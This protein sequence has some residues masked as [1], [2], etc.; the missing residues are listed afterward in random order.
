MFERTH[1]CG[2]LRDSHVGERV[3]VAG[4]VQKR[5]DH[6]GLIF[7]DL[8][9]RSG[10]VQAVVDPNAAPDAF[11]AAHRVRPEFVL[12]VRG[13]VRPRPEGTVNPNLPTGEVEVEMEGLEVLNASKTPPFEIEDDVD[14]D[15]A[16]RL[17]YRYLD[18]RRRPMLENLILRDRIVQATRAYLGEQGFLEVETP[19]LTKSTPEGARDFL[20]PSRLQPG[21]FYALPQSPQLFKQVLMVGG[22]ER[23]YQIA[24]CFRDEDLRAD[25]QPEY[26]QID[27]EMS[28]VKQ[29]DILALVE[30]M[31]QAIGAAA[32]VDIKTPLPRMTHSEAMS[33]YGSDKPD[34][35]FD[36]E[37]VDL[38]QAISGSQFRVFADAASGG[39]VIKGIRVPGG[40]C[41]SRKDL[42][43]LTRF[44]RDRGGKGLAW[45][46]FA[47][48][49]EPRSPIAKFLSEEEIA[50]IRD[51]LGAEGGDAVLLVADKPDM[52]N[53]LL[54]LVRLEVA[55][56]LGL[57][58][59]E[60]LHMLWLTD[61]PLFMWDDEQNRL[62]SEHHPFTMPSE[63]S[64]A[65]LDS[66][67]LACSAV[68][69]DLVLNGTELGS[70]TIRIHDRELQERIFTMLQMSSEEAK[71]KFGFLLDA[72]QFGA[73]PHGGIALG[74]DRLVMLLAGCVSIRDVIAFPKTQA[75]SDL[76]TGAPDA[77]GEGQLRDLHIK[78]R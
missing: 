8:R 63:E 65:L 28:F 1:H 5:R 46:I 77:V 35:R 54:G 25:R 17:K 49:G 59:D 19:V 67:P 26:T 21:H 41:L 4:W 36:L 18:L 39:G 50:T 78:L 70:G 6:G 68:A 52:A 48:D 38:T 16:I 51:G 24:R 43:E 32:G 37:L 61:F 34:L 66:E 75:G 22:I 76:M 31:L 2:G 64:L 55:R 33:T 42:D 44:A 20:T 62:D 30:G 74:L 45:I 15:E 47:T 27:M 53:E 29:D 56:R 10:V 58:K 3:V 72:L 12:V 60:S 14:A 23:Y 11:E 69:F 73:P 57:V 13:T 7:I 71:E 9:D 40:D